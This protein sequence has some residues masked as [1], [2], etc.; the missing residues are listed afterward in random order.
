MKHTYQVIQADFTVI[1]GGI[2]GIVAA[3]SAAR[4]GLTV[5]LVQDRPVLGGNHSS[6]CRVHLSSSAG[7]GYGQYNRE[8]GIVDEIKQSILHFNPR[9]NKKLD[10]DLTDMTLLYMVKK[11]K[12][13]TLFLNT[14][15]NEVEKEEEYIVAVRGYNKFE[16]EY[17]QFVSPLFA[18]AS[19]NGV[20]A[21]N[22]GV[23]SFVGREG[24]EKYGENLASEVA[25]HNVMGSCILFTVGTANQEIPFVKPNF[26]YDY[27]EDGIL[28]WVNR[29]ET[30]RKLPVN[31]KE[32]D[33][34]WWLSYG[35]S[36]DT[37]KDHDAI[38]FEL[39]KLV[40]GF[41]DYV[42]N[43]GAYKNTENYYINWIAPF[44]A[45]RESR[46]FLGDYVMTEHDLLGKTEIKD[47]IA[48][49]GWSID[50]HD[51]EGVYGSGKISQFGK[52][53]ALYNVSYRS[54]YAKE[55]E[56]LFLCG[57]ILSAS[58]IAL[59]SLRVMQ[60]L[61]AIAEST[62]VAASLCKKYGVLPRAISQ[63]EYLKELQDTI[64][65]DGVYVQDRKEDVGMM[66]EAV[67][68]SSSEAQLENT[69]LEEFVTIIEDLAL[70]LPIGIL[71]SLEICLKACEDTILEIDFYSGNNE[72]IYMATNR[73]KRISIKL[74]K[75]FLGYREI[76]ANIENIPNERVYVVLRKNS[77]VEVGTAYDSLV[78]NLS[79]YFSNGRLKR[80]K[81]RH[82]R[83]YSTT[84][85]I[86]FQNVLPKQNPYA[87][88]QV[89]NGYQRPVKNPNI[90]IADA[91]DKRPS[92]YVEFKRYITIKEI[93]LLFNSEQ[94][95]DHFNQGIPSLVKDYNIVIETEEGRNDIIEVRNNYL[96]L[97]THYVSYQKT[98]KITVTLLENYGSRYKGIF[99]MKVF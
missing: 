9:Y 52:V 41:W 78:G 54:T 8:S 23:T 12:N 61:G 27:E 84:Y 60:I 58:H 20:V 33:G 43:S 59:G 92:I 67:I 81:V 25:D 31:L 70:A 19:G 47:R 80:C 7:R 36:L 34:I 46:R 93:Q 44:P 30:G 29:P 66:E 51:T 69:K 35:G 83:Y 56:N 90:W 86:C 39:K 76:I 57:R 65:K 21:Y 11:E 16:E 49:G 79:F 71:D 96:A 15:V 91:K 64:Q 17:Y 14:V 97:N 73:L 95:K 5:S 1:G 40:Y 55:I 26:A 48:T 63:G 38:D 87:A 4:K 13:I 89:K 42:K 3:V 98:K 37:I 88:L 18:D 77:N 50:I 53:D 24:K 10:Y 82:S 75:G 62:G 72:K 22:A 85:N 74:E 68:T 45:M 28:K 2:S 6:E 94:D 32:V 99:G